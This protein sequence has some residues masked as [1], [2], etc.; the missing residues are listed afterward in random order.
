MADELYYSRHTG[1]VIDDAIS[2]VINTGGSGTAALTASQVG[3]APAGFGYGETML[4]IDINNSESDFNAALENVFA[5]MN[6]GTT[7]QIMFANY[8]VYGN[9]GSVYCGTL[10]KSGANY[11]VL[12]GTSY[13]GGTLQK[14]KSTNWQPW[15]WVNPPMAAGVEY[16]TTE[17]YLGKQ[18]YVKVVDCGALPNNTQKSI[19]SSTPNIDRIVSVTGRRYSADTLDTSIP[20]EL[21]NGQKVTVYANSLGSIYIYANHDASASTASVI[22]KY[23]KTT[24]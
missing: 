17:R 11:G 21:F 10:Y 22:L 24:G 19:N 4:K 5:S 13:S 20:F 14:V 7:K 15:E 23:T 1:P 6:N 9:D 12:R 2:K 16:R 18:V 8:P 3:A